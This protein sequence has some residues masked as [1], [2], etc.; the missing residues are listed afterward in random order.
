MAMAC[1]VANL[2]NPDGSTQRPSFSLFP[3]NCRMRLSPRLDQLKRDLHAIVQ[4]RGNHTLPPQLNRGRSATSPHQIPM[5]GWK[6]ILVRSWAEISENNIVGG[7]DQR[8]VRTPDAGGFNRWKSGV[9]GPPQG[10]SRRHCRRHDF[11]AT[12]RCDVTLMPRRPREGTCRRLSEALSGG[13]DRTDQPNFYRDARGE[14]ERNGSLSGGGSRSA[15][16]SG[17]CCRG[18][19]FAA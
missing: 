19:T 16:L 8:A 7:G 4:S 15:A 17:V 6:D 13:R 14:A 3:R 1:G 10:R 12:V 18:A 11:L 2:S 5:P 9:D